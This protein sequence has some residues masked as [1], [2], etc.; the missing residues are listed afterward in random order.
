MTITRTTPL[1]P[2]SAIVL[3]SYIVA[4]YF[5]HKTPTSGDRELARR[6][7]GSISNSFGARL[8][9]QAPPK[10][11]REKDPPTTVAAAVRG[12]GRFKNQ[13]SQML[14]AFDS[15]EA[16]FELKGLNADQAGYRA[17]LLNG[18]YWKR[19]SELRHLGLI[20]DTGE[21]RK[22]RSGQPQMVC[23]LTVWG[24]VALAAI[25]NQGAS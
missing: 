23:R 7:I 18:C 24:E 21:P 19:F 3:A 6:V 15:D 17:G 10:A 20:E 8:L 25:K 5:D 14:L 22:G 1:I 2:D 13:R 4:E 12:L 9:D 16:R 11:Y